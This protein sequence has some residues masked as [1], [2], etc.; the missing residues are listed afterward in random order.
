MIRRYVEGTDLEDVQ[1]LHAR[2]HPTWPKRE[3]AWWWSHPT[4]VLELDGVVVGSTSMAVSL[5]ATPQL[6]EWGDAVLYGHGVSVDPEHRG[7][8]YG[9]ELAEARH[10]AGTALGAKLFVG[11]TWKANRAM[12]AIFD[13]QGLQRWGQI[14]VTGAYPHNDPPADGLLYIGRL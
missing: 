10:L 13:K 4:L 7:Q 2:A 5:P 11:M 1:A 12:R 8:G 3:A 14:V 6:A 9:L